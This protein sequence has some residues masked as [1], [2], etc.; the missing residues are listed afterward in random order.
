MFDERK[1]GYGLVGLG[2]AAVLFAASFGGVAGAASSDPVKI[3]L[4]LAKRGVMTEQAE[5]L[6]QG[7]YLALK[8][9]GNKILGRPAEIIWLDEPTPQ[10]AQ[11]NMQKLIDENKVVA[12]LGGGISAN[13]LAMEAV[14]KRAKIP[15]IANNAAATEITGK[16]CNRYTFRIQPPVSVQANALAPYL[17]KL[18]K[19]WHFLTANYAFGQDIEGAFGSWLKQQGGTVAGQDRAP[20]NTPDFSSFILKIRT[21]KP[22]VVIGGLAA[23]DLTNFLKQWNE[24]G[25]KDTVPFSEVA[26]SDTD[27]WGVGREAATGIYTTPWYYDNPN[28]SEQDKKFVADYEKEYK[29]VPAVKAWMGWYAM[30]SLLDSIEDAKSTDPK[31]IVTAL[32]NWRDESAGETPASYRKW[33]H[34]LLHPILV[35][36]VKKNIPDSTNFFDVLQSVPEGPEDLGKIFGTQ[37]QSSCKMGDL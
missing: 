2:C 29:R 27:L 10:D 37:E 20:L 31:A 19:R 1:S 7:T 14:A 25:M 36:R 23:A 22:D 3:G 8:Q 35:V 21:S 6:A 24:M 13:A 26:I 9:H 32:E 18:G 11:Q 16:E 33:D 30:R 28:N 12:V 5:Y 34:Q 17:G 4:V 15:Y